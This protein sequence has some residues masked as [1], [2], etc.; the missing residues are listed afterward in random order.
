MNSRSKVEPCETRKWSSYSYAW[1]KGIL[2][3][4]GVLFQPSRM[5]GDAYK[6]S[7]YLAYDRKFDKSKESIVLDLES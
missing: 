6:V 4:T 5:A 7:V 3:Q 2:S 1:T